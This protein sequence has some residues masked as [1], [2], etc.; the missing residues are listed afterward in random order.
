L[1]EVQIAEIELSQQKIAAEGQ[2]LQ[3]D[4]KGRRKVEG[5]FRPSRDHTRD[6][7]D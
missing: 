6:I 3:G 5:A 2:V 4:V 7:K 1:E